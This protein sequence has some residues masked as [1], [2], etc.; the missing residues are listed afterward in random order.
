M[1]VKV[2][3]AMVSTTGAHGK[4]GSVK[5]A[6]TRV[7]LTLILLV[8][9]LWWREFGFEKA[10]SRSWFERSSNGGMKGWR[11][12]EVRSFLHPHLELEI[13]PLGKGGL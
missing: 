3:L 1:G 10:L 13:A 6:F 5:V 12:G 7:G 2:R 11:W 8:I 4:P 9:F